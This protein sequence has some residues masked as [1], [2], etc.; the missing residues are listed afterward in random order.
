MGDGSLL[1]PVVGLLASTGLGAWSLHAAYGRLRLW[2]EVA[3]TPTQRVRSVAL[4]RAELKGLAEP[5]G[6]PLTGPFSGLPC[7]WWRLTVEQE[8]TSTDSKGQVTKN[9]REIH[10]ASSD[11]P[12]RLHDGDAGIVVLP[13][14]GEIEA[15]RIFDAVTPFGGRFAFGIYLGGGGLPVK[16]PQTAQWESSGPL[17]PQRRLR[18][19]QI[20]VKRPLYVLGWVR[21]LPQEAGGGL[22]IGAARLGEPFLVSTKDE[23]ELLS[24]LRWSA[25]G[26]LFLAGLALAA[27]IFVLL[28]FFA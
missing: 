25:L 1:G 13:E 24:G 3:D 23:T 5:L 10:S 11:A 26:L 17:M 16:G 15:P 7:C 2:R 6:D 4:G 9:W 22:G 12:F 28:R 20:G 8:E 21:S 19:W 14:G 18:E 27:F